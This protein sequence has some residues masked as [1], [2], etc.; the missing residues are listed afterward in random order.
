MSTFLN[1]GIFMTTRFTSSEGR[2]IAE[3]RL[4]HRTKIVSSLQTRKPVLKNGLS[5]KK[6]NE[7]TNQTMLQLCAI[8]QTF[9]RKKV[10]DAKKRAKHWVHSA[11]SER[12]VV[13]S[14]DRLGKFFSVQTSRVAGRLPFFRVQPEFDISKSHRNCVTPGC[15]NRRGMW[16]A[17]RLKGSMVAE[18]SSSYVFAGLTSATETGPLRVKERPCHGLRRTVAKGRNFESSGRAPKVH[19]ETFRSIRAFA[20]C[21]CKFAG[22]PVYET[23][24]LETSLKL[25]VFFFKGTKQALARSTPSSMALNTVGTENSTGQLS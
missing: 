4:Q 25:R 6:V 1:R 16:T 8:D 18:Y 7:W 12:N 24:G 21:T 19:Q 10:G 3:G 9:A 2:L 13:R 20:L 14:F 5:E 23:L 15:T 11:C 17:G 22:W